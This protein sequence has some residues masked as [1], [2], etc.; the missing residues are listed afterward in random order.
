MEKQSFITDL[1][2]ETVE[3]NINYKKYV[4]IIRAV[5]LG[6]NDILMFIVQ[7]TDGDLG[8]VHYGEVTVLGKDRSH[9][10]EQA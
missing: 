4:G 8:R 6:A 3:C 1:L 10:Q 9:N 5:Y 7:F 2:G